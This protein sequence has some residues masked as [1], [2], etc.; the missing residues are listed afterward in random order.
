[1]ALVADIQSEPV[2]LKCGHPFPHQ[3]WEIQLKYLRSILVKVVICI[4][5][6]IETVIYFDIELD[7]SVLQQY[8][9]K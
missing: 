3:I 4:N 9:T 8:Q 1:M 7:L 5:F 6:Q 2:D